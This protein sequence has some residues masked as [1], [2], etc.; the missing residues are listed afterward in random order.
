MSA[1]GI[2][3]VQSIP[4]LNVAKYMGRWYQIK[5][6]PK[7][8]QE[9]CNN[10]VAEYK[11]KKDH[12]AVK[13]SCRQDG[14]LKVAEGKAYPANKGKSQLKV[15]FVGGRLFEGDYWVLYTDYNVALVGTP[16]K[17]SLWILSRNPTIKKSDLQKLEHIAKNQGFDISKLERQ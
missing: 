9:G 5:A 2:K 11:L 7:W 6:I 3:T 14:E 4:S 16:D 8:F 13:N 12:I 10:V 1:K 17:E 15:D